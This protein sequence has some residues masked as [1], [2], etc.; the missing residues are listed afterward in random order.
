MR[1]RVDSDIVA[2]E[3]WMIGQLRALSSNTLVIISRT[4]T[5]LTHTLLESFAT[6]FGRLGEF[7]TITILVKN[8]RTRY[9]F[10][11]TIDCA[12]Y[13]FAVFDIDSIHGNNV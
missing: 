13:I 5:L 11:E 10:F 9:H 8:S 7:L 12:L 6:N 2:T 1:V 3:I 4:T